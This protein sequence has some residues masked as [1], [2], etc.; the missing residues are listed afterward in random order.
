M[1]GMSLRASDMTKSAT[2]CAL[3]AFILWNSGGL[4]S[5][6]TL[7]SMNE[8]TECSI[9]FLQSRLSPYCVS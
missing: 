9:S 4:M 2:S 7:L 6:I 3:S 8:K 1:S 5:V